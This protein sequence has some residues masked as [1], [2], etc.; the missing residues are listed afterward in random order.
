MPDDKHIL[1]VVVTLTAAGL[2]QANFIEKQGGELHL[3]MDTTTATK[4]VTRLRLRI[5]DADATRG[6]RIRNA[7]V[8]K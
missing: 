5:A 4:L 6:A 7:F 3:M 2:I 8:E 1:D